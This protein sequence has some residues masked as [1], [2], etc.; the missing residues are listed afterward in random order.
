MSAQINDVIIPQSSY[1]SIVISQSSDGQPSIT[2]NSYAVQVGTYTFSFFGGVQSLSITLEDP[3]PA[4]L[5]ADLRFELSRRV[6]AGD[7]TTAGIPLA[8]SSSAR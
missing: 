8:K 6:V 4:V 2:I 3:D 7:L 1:D 5:Q